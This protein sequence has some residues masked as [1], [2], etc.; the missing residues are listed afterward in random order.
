MPLAKKLSLYTRSREGLTGAIN[1]CKVNIPNIPNFQINRDA[2]DIKH[3]HTC[4]TEF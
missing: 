1:D 3:K 4:S 2:W